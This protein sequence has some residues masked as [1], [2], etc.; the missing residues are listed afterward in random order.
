MATPTTYKDLIGIFQTLCDQH[1]AVKFFNWS[2]NLSD[3]EVNQPEYPE[4]Q[5]IYVFLQ[6]LNTTFNRGYAIYNANLIVMDL[7]RKNRE[8]VL[9]V[10]DTTLSVLQD[11]LAKIRLTTW[12]E[13]DI[14]VQSPIVCTPFVESEKQS[15]AG[16]SASIQIVTKNPLDLCD[17]AFVV[18]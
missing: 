13:L 4:Q 2:V 3:I 8:A 11:L 1:L 16:W 17:A 12:S 7:A 10:H 6:P 5:Y 18:Y 9:E 14:Q 15:T